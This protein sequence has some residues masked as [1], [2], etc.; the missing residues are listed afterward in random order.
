MAAKLLS[1]ESAGMT[2]Q[3][4]P[5]QWRQNSRFAAKASQPPAQPGTG[6][7]PP[8]ELQRLQAQMAEINSLSEQNARK[9]HD[10]G[11]RA[12]ELS[13]R[14]ALEGE[15][16]ACT[17]KLA[18]TIAELVTTREQII[19]RAE[20]DTVLLALEIARRVLHRE[21]SVDSSA[22]EALV[23]AAIEKLRNQE[24]YRVRIHPDQ[25][26]LVRRCLQ[27]MGRGQEIEIV[28]DPAQSRGGAFFEIGRGALDASVDTQLRE[29][30]RGL[31]DVIE[32]RK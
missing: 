28:S 2:A 6:D 27:Q 18:Q 9:A 8:N 22:I 16:R 21:L 5:L 19:R 25:E 3:A 11:Y 29:I 4:T 24:I 23:K 10:A 30:E 13:A 17:E 1:S 32:I 14:K 20:A 7:H 31:A 15:M 12:G 26:E